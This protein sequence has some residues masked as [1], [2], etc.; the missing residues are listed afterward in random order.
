M[1]VVESLKKVHQIR[2]VTGSREI[3]KLSVRGI[4]LRSH[5]SVAIGMF[6]ALAAAGVNVEMIN[7]SELSVNVVVASQH[8]QRRIRELEAEICREFGITKSVARSMRS[9]LELFRLSRA[10]ASTATILV[11]LLTSI[12]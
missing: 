12:L 2:Q 7:T 3:A 1:Q 5:T 6:D 8:G 9:K 4:G 10:H 11:C